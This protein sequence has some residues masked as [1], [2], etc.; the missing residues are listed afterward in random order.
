MR[1]IWKKKLYTQLSR[2]NC[3]YIKCMYLKCI[4][5]SIYFYFYFYLQLDKF[6]LSYL[7]LNTW[8]KKCFWYLDSTMVTAIHKGIL[9]I[10]QS[11]FLYCNSILNSFNLFSCLTVSSNNGVKESFKKVYTVEYAYG[12][13]AW[14]LALCLVTNLSEI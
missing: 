1:W 2:W 12:L 6:A 3:M 8:V 5:K 4:W 13:V 7:Y 9:I 10:I 14:L 11:I